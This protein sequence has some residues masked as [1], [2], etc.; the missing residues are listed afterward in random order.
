MPYKAIPTLRYLRPR[1]GRADGVFLLTDPAGFADFPAPRP[2]LGA[3]CRAALPRSALPRAAL[4]RSA[5]LAAP[6]VV[7]PGL[8]LRALFG[9]APVPDLLFDAVFVGLL[10]DARGF[11]PRCLGFVLAL[12]AFPAALGVSLLVAFP[13]ALLSPWCIGFLAFA[14][15]P[16]RPAK[17]SSARLGARR[18]G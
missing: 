14:G 8:A 1:L 11:P 13:A 16:A 17:E 4:P 12:R 15:V 10:S 7:F 9:V 6:V 3:S 5:R 18:L 2:F